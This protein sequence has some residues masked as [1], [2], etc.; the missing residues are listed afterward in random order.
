MEST[1]E[2]EISEQGAGLIVPAREAASSLLKDLCVEM[3]GEGRVERQTNT[4]TRTHTHTETHNTLQ[5]AFESAAF[6]I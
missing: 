4:H 6:H 5:M 3:K 1:V 2:R